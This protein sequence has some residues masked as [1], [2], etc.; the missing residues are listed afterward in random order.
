MKYPDVLSCWI[1][2]AVFHATR[3]LLIGLFASLAISQLRA[4]SVSLSPIAASQTGTG[5]GT[6]QATTINS[7]TVWQNTVNSAGS[8]SHNLYFDVPASIS[9]TG[10]VYIQVKYYDQGV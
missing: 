5:D 1:H 9:T 8:R 4:T 3:V 6:W 2:R 10:Y 7:T